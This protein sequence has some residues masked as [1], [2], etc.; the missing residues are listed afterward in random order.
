MRMTVRRA[1]ER[2]ADVIKAVR[3]GREVVLTDR[4]KRVAVVKPW[5]L[6]EREEAILRRLEAIGLV[7][8]ATVRAPM[9]PFRPLRIKGEP[10]TA[11]LRRERDE[12]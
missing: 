6:P 12:R 2:F 3:A 4:G 9:P 8:R 7:R 10:I 1:S 11:T 5:S